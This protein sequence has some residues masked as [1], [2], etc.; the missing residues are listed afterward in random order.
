MYKQHARLTMRLQSC[1][2]AQ[3]AYQG[4]FTIIYNN[5]ERINENKNI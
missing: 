5:N 3:R 4:V 1:L 2:D